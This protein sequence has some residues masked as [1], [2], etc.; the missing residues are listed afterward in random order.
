MS[1]MLQEAIDCLLGEGWDEEAGAVADLVAEIER[2]RELIATKDARIAE[3]EQIATAEKATLL[4][5]AASISPPIPEELIALYYNNAKKNKGRKMTK[6]AKELSLEGGYVARLEQAFL[7]IYGWKRV[8]H[9][10]ITSTEITY[11]EARA[12]LTKIREG[13]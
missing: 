3:R 2:L 8:A 11:N 1:D 13:K 9:G 10:E 7:D 6:A 5:F 12:A 4:E